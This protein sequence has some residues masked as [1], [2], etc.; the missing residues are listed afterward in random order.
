LNSIQRTP[1]GSPAQ[2]NDLAGFISHHTTREPESS[3]RDR[4]KIKEHHHVEPAQKTA[5]PPHPFIPVSQPPAEDAMA[6]SEWEP[7][8]P[9]NV[10]TSAHHSLQDR[11]ASNIPSSQEAAV[12]LES[13]RAILAVIQRHKAALAK[14]AAERKQKAAAFIDRQ[15]TATRVSP[16]SENSQLQNSGQKGAK[17]NKRVLQDESDED[18]EFSHD[19]RRIDIATK[20]AKMRAKMPGLSKRRRRFYEGDSEQEIE[21]QL[22]SEM[23]PSSIDPH[24]ESKRHSST[25]RSH[26]DR[27]SERSISVSTDD[28]AESA[29]TRAPPAAPSP[30]VASRT[31]HPPSRDFVPP[32]VRR[33]WTKPETERLIQ[34]M[35]KLGPH[36][37]VIKREDELT[38]LRDGGP[39]FT[40][41]DPQQI[42]DR[43]RNMVLEFYRYHIISFRVRETSK[44]NIINLF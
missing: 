4:V 24:D 22:Q 34:L 2:E 36:W 15:M 26:D 5:A 16:I 39:L 42:K 7:E 17:I 30:P 1:Q 29:R 14:K 32:N 18:D 28:L 43:A 11:A 33:R 12:P 31:F 6:D 23:F 44:A 40:G 37:A 38:S 25:L 27:R 13:S 3:R 20:R 41:K 35:A 19:N 8:S 10:R 9:S 21:R